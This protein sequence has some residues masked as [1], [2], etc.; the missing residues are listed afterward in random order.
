[1]TLNK[2]LEYLVFIDTE[3]E[4][5]QRPSGKKAITDALVAFCETIEHVGYYAGIYSSSYWCQHLTELER[6]WSAHKLK[7]NV[8][9]ILST[10]EVRNWEID[11][12]FQETVNSGGYNGLVYKD[13]WGRAG[14]EMFEEWIPGVFAGVLWDE[15]DHKVKPVRELEGPEVMIVVDLKT[16]NYPG[17]VNSSEAQKYFSVLQ[18]NQALKGTMIEQEQTDTL[19]T[20][21]TEGINIITANNELGKL[22][23]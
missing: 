20:T 2:A 9:K 10:L 21:L 23:W 4:Y 14:F 11:W 5:H 8:A 7:R 22:S 16:P 12:P 3:D 19:Y 15:C 17:V 18:A 13:R 1:M 6:Y